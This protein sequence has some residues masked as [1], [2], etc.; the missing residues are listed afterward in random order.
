MNDVSIIIPTFNRPDD[1]AC[2]LPYYINQNEVLEIIIVDDG[3][4]LSYEKVI[5]KYR[6][7]NGISIVYHK[8]EHNL[9]AG[10][11]RNV[12]LNLAV[13]KYILWGEDDAFIADDYVS[14]LKSKIYDKEIVLGSIY[15]GIHPTMSESERQSII[16]MQQKSG[17]ALFDYK[18]M[19]GYYRLKTD[20]DIRIPWGHAL[21]MAKKEAYDNVAYYE[22]YKVNGYREETDA[23]IQMAEHGYN[24]IY[25]SDTCCY[26]FPAHNSSGGQHSSK[27]LKFEF[28][29]I[30]NNNIFLD[31]HYSFL[32]TEYPFTQ[33]KL[34]YKFRFA[35]HILSSLSKR[36]LNK[37][38][39]IIGL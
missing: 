9:G 2:V 26:H 21:L 3:S 15:Y 39:R 35:Y 6:N 8:N 32:H 13:G 5:S 25:T 28:Y 16:Q 11:S 23:Q 20:E 29:K 37:L 33:S 38:Q 19:E 14:T 31:R 18:L 30:I 12:G 4:D 22:G 34:F 27:I 36:A 17:K 7:P 1:L 10:A 24:I